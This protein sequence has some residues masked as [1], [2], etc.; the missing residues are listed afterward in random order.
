MHSLVFALSQKPCKDETVGSILGRV[1][2]PHLHVLLTWSIEYQLSGSR[3]KCGSS[4]QFHHIR[5]MS[6]LR[7]AE[8]P[9]VVESR[10]LQSQVFVV[11]SSAKIDEHFEEHPELESCAQ[12]NVR[13]AYSA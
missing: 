9:N 7:H 6:Q 5:A 10:G 3:I 12:C 11:L 1:T 4:P 13:Y 2:N 8:S